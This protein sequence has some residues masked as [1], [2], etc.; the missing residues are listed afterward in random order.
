MWP[1]SDVLMMV[2]WL[3]AD[4]DPVDEAGQLCALQ[5]RL[6]VP[7][8]LLTYACLQQSRIASK[9]HACTYDVSCHS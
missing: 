2:L 7:L 9:A 6:Q 3:H 4:R 5:L 1:V 8:L